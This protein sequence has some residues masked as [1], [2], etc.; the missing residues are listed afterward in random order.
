MSRKRSRQKLPLRWLLTAGLVAS[1]DNFSLA[2]SYQEVQLA[3]LE[4]FFE[5]TNGERW[6]LSMGWLDTSVEVCG[7]YG[8]TCDESGENVIGLALPGNGLVGDL[9]AADQFFDI[10]SIKSVD[11]SDNELTG[12]VTLGFGLMPNL[13]TLDLSRNNLLSFPSNWGSEASS[14]QHLLLQHNSISG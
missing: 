3:G 6:S 5:S 10:V 1:W 11:L 4:A 8:L 14:L 13:E 9:S 7:W 2:Q 12:P